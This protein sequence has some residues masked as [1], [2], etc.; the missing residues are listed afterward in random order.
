AGAA[1]PHGTPRT[2]RFQAAGR[3]Q[4]HGRRLSAPEHRGRD[5]GRAHHDRRRDRRAPLTQ[6]ATLG[7]LAWLETTAAA[8]AMR[9][10]LWLYP[11]VERSSTSS[12]SLS[13]SAAR[14]CST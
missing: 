11:I 9:Q 5:A 12:A 14:R 1:D 13:S 2:A 3:S 10:S 4:G 7:W 6:A 8:T